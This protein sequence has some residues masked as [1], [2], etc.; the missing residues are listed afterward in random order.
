M[1]TKVEFQLS[2]SCNR[3][4]RWCP[5]FV[6]KKDNSDMVVPK[7]IIEKMMN[8]I[9]IYNNLFCNELRIAFSRYNEPLLHAD[10]LNEYCLYI[11]N[12][13]NSTTNNICFTTINTNG[14]F[15]DDKTKA[16]LSCFE[17]V[18]INDYNGMSLQKSLL[19]ILN[20]FGLNSYK[21]IIINK[22]R[23]EIYFIYNNQNYTLAYSK[24]VYM[25]IRTRGGLLDNK[26][27]FVRTTKCDVIGKLIE[28]DYNGDVYPCCEVSS[29]NGEHKE[30]CCGNILTDDFKKIYSNINDIKVE[31]HKSIC[32]SCNAYYGC[33]K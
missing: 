14:D 6:N 10:K 24:N 21:T 13:I 32:S 31:K 33:V 25:N 1:I 8:N 15:L 12:Y 23:K 3:K 5:Q 22:E 11:K 16:L 20:M 2:N 9:K 26:N 27:N 28:I 29:M 4:C 30:M 17:K 18:T 19:Y 7:K